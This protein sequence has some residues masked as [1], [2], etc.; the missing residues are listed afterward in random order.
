MR[1]MRTHTVLLVVCLLFL[2]AFS[3][4]ARAGGPKLTADE[5]LAKHLDSLASAEVRAAAKTR[6]VEGTSSFVIKTGG[7]G[8]CKDGKG[9]LLS[10]G[11]KTALGMV[12]PVN[13]YPG[14]RIIFNGE[15]FDVGHINPSGLRSPLGGLLNQD[16]EILR[17]G[18]FG[19]VLTTAWPLLNFQ[20]R[21][22][23]LKYDGI[24]K[25]DGVELHRLSYVPKKANNGLQVFLFFDAQTFRH[26]KTLYQLEIQPGAPGSVAGTGGFQDSGNAGHL[27][28]PNTRYKLE[29][30]FSEFK[31]ED[32]WTLPT[33]W[34]IRYTFDPSS[35]QG[36]TIIDYDLLLKSVV[37]NSGVD[38]KTFVIE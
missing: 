24:K 15:K 20:D 8:L 22:A 23:K 35:G 2:P 7:Q 37:N 26:V 19:G 21:Q 9:V 30:D 32:G 12:F 13:N 14:E 6:A 18:L 29:E 16:P 10:E 1:K 4:L 27:Y 28:N 25:I 34:K 11:R 5:V 3:T 33:R 17:E 36:V 31:T 38:P